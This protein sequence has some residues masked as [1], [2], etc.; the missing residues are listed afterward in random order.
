MSHPIDSAATN[1]QVT[2]SSPK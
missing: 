1:E 2:V